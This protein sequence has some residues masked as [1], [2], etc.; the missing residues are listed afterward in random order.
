V[1]EMVDLEINSRGLS[2][3]IIAIGLISAS[4]LMASPIVLANAETINTVSVKETLS[5]QSSLD[6]NGYRLLPAEESEFDNVRESAA[7]PPKPKVASGEE[8]YQDSGFGEYL[9][10][11]SSL[12]TKL[13]MLR[14]LS[15]QTPPTQVFLHAIS[16][17][18]GVDEM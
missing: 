6:E 9:Y 16:M 12:A 3:S 8:E 2:H 15:K 14:L 1:K 17:G 13:E 18:V 4:F 11:E 5:T 7:P 10:S